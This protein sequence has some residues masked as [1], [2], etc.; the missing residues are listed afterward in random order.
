MV[1][2]EFVLLEVADAFAEPPLRAV[3]VEFYRGLQQGATP[4]TLEVVPVSEDLLARGWML[5][6]QRPDKGW[7]VTDCISMVVIQERGITDAFTSDH[8][9][10]QAGFTILLSHNP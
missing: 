7:G 10:M 2:T 8:H 9:F 6:G 3:S 4:L 5:Y 1:T